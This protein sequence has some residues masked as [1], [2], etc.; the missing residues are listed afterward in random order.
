MEDAR[1]TETAAERPQLPAECQ[2]T[3]DDLVLMI[4]EGAIRERQQQRVGAWY[5]RELAALRQDCLKMQSLLAQAT[6]RSAEMESRCDA[7]AA[8]G[9]QETDSLRTR[10]GNLEDQVHRT[11]LERDTARKALTEAETA[12]ARE[13]ASLRT[14]LGEC[15]QALAAAAPAPGGKRKGKG[16]PEAG[17]RR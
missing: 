16:A 17:T 6:Q 7:T 8:T 2:M 5:E 9:R 13:T 10:I 14:R 11:A 3:T 15:E 12:H 4:G 1:V